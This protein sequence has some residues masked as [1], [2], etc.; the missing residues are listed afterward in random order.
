LNP[1]KAT[2]G[3]QEKGELKSTVPMPPDGTPNSPGLRDFFF[4][5]A[6]DLFR[7]RPQLGEAYFAAFKAADAG[8]RAEKGDLKGEPDRAGI[9]AQ[10]LK[11]ALGNTIDFNGAQ[12]KVPAGMD[13]SKFKGYVNNAVAA[14]VKSAGGKDDWADRI[15]GYRL[16]EQ[17][18][19]GSGRYAI[20]DG[21]IPIMRPDGKGP[22]TIDLRQQYG[23]SA[24]AS[25]PAAAP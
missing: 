17:D 12:V 18:G 3:Q 20:M 16:H 6:K 10:A 23:P 19:V 22:L 13:P 7:D 5:K 9:E 1:S 25:R 21:P 14:V 2:T 4:G 24:A 15:Q 8:L 11:I